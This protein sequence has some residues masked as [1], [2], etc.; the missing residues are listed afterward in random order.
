ML[1]TVT[2]YQVRILIPY[3]QAKGDILCSDHSPETAQPH[4]CG[5]LGHPPP[6][7]LPP[8][9]RGGFFWPTGL[10]TNSILNYSLATSYIKE[11]SKKC[12]FLQ[13]PKL[14]LRHLFLRASSSLGRYRY[15]RVGTLGGV[16]VSLKFR[17]QHTRRG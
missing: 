1:S 9:P 11:Q 15:S 4:F 10:V 8:Q 12:F 6:E 5:G 3:K 13:K 16:L 2:A 7:T 14:C 17:K